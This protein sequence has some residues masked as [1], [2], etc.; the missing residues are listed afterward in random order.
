[1]GIQCTITIKH[2]LTLIYKIAYFIKKKLN[3]YYIKNGRMS[4]SQ[5]L[6]SGY[7]EV[8]VKKYGVH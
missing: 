3:Q 5:H 8:L 7:T 4:P 1:M 6:A 2:S